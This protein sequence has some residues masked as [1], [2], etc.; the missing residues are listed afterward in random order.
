MMAGAVPNFGALNRR[1]RD[2][3]LSETDVIIAAGIH[4]QTWRAL[5]RASADARRAGTLRRVADALD[6]LSANAPTRMPSFLRALVLAA[7]DLLRVRIAGGG[8]E[9]SRLIAACNPRLSGYT[10]VPKGRLRTLAIY[11][12]AVEID[13]GRP[14]I[15]AAIAGALGT[16]RQNVKKARDTIEAIRE[17][18]GAL[19]RLIARVSDVLNGRAP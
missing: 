1:R 5:S 13:G 18:G 10:A 17:D 14:G 16:T 19:D 6:R 3:G 9:R 4:W 2:L 15:N 7:E 12:V 8:A 11:I